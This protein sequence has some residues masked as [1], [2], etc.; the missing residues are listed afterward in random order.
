MSPSIVFAGTDGGGVFQTINGGE[1]WAPLNAGLS[2]LSVLS[3]VIDPTGN[4]LH[5]GTAGGGVFDYQISG[6]LPPAVTGVVPQSGPA[7]G[8]TMVTVNGLGFAQGA[9]VT[10]G[11]V[12]LTNVVFVSPTQITGNTGPHGPGATDLVVTNPDSQTGTFTNGYVYDFSDVPPADPFHASV[13]ALSRNGITSGCGGGNYCPTADVARSQMSVF[14]LKSKLGPCYSPPP[15]TVPIFTDV[16]C[17]SPFSSW[18][19]QLVSE[20][21]TS[22][23]TQTTFCPNNSVQR[24]SMAVFLLVTEHGMGYTP[25]ACTP[26][27]QFTDVPCP[28]GGFTDWIYQLV[29]EGITGGCTATTYCP[30]SPVLRS[31]MA[32]FL[33][34]TFS[35]Q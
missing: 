5:A 6:V 15:C 12:S 13:V 26:P 33:V 22:G 3:L 27:G 29:A 9:T 24:N 18:I 14:L 32:A 28:G 21:I 10:V 8:G 31:Q 1:I 4:V 35:L 2:N 34:T 30:G 23:C 25:P 7:T 20:G 19:Y 11:G 17:S 16:P